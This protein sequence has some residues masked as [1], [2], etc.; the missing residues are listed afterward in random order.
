[1][2][3][4]SRDLLACCGLYCGDCIR[5]HSRAS[6]LS[7]E[8][9]AE[10]ERVGYA[11]YAEAQAR[12]PTGPDEFADFDRALGVLGAIGK[13]C[14]ETSCRQG[15]CLAFQCRVI[16]CCQDKNLD[17]CW[18]C[19]DLEGCVELDFLV[20]FHGDVKLWLRDIRDQG[21][22]SFLQNRPKLYMW[23]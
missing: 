20:P 4:P 3:E 18:G 22:E 23:L 12:A 10:L 7:A 2:T 13:F 21:V 5:Y 17:G 15:G 1:M 9:L 16:A 14:C 6:E 8:L 11:E 19:G